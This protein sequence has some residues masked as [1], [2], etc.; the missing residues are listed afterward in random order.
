MLTH[1]DT[2]EPKGAAFVEFADKAAIAKA[3]RLHK[4]SLDGRK[5][6]IELSAGGGGKSQAR[7]EKIKDKQKSL[8]QE[9]DTAYKRRAEGTNPSE[10]LR[11]NH[12]KGAGKGAS[13]EDKKPPESVGEPPSAEIVEF[14]QKFGLTSADATSY[15]QR[16]APN[17]LEVVL[18]TFQL[19]DGARDP[20]AIL[21]RFGEAV[22]RRLGE[23]EN[24]EA[25][26][27]PEEPPA[28]KKKSKQNLDA[29]KVKGDP[30]ESFVEHKRSKQ[31]ARPHAP[32]ETS[33]N[34]DDPEES[35]GKQKK[36]KRKKLSH[37]IADTAQA[38]APAEAVEASAGAKANKKKKKKK[39]L[40]SRQIKKL[41]AKEKRSQEE[42]S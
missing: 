22:K 20:T 3:L 15:L 12:R 39:K 2:G 28:K 26:D 40:G 41:R 18:S 36:S 17:V 16:L 37:A 34:K 23:G 29:A 11:K 33:K 32:T 14:N 31:K 35:P 9:R 21:V 13:S 7:V 4:A 25:Q 42:N 24:A 30:G 5:I 6:R 19:R 38:V 10:H 27:E 8:L 1:K